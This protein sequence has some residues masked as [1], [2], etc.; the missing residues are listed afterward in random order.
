[1]RSADYRGIFFAVSNELL[2]TIPKMG[3]ELSI[4][5][6]L[7]DSPS[8]V[9][10]P[11]EQE[12]VRTYYSFIRERLHASQGTYRREVARG[13]MQGFLFELCGMLDQVKPAGRPL[14]S[15]KSRKEYL[16]E[17]FYALLIESYQTERSVRF[18]AD[19]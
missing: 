5:F 6:F 2:E 7:K 8:F 14:P 9:L 13:L 4:F 17:R 3:H 11:E 12:V 19:Q 10:K 18:Y 1:S 15:C 16:F